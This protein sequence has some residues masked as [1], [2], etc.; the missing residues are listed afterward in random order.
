MQVL[1]LLICCQLVTDKED[2]ARN[3][4]DYYV[5]IDCATRI[6][7]LL[8][9]TGLWIPSLM[10]DML[11]NKNIVFADSTCELYI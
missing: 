8:D 10:P 5:T 4:D 9:L 7:N 11:P 1:S 2:R 3:K 6:G